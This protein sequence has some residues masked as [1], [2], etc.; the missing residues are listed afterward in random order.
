MAKHAH[1]V[2]TNFAV[3]VMGSPAGWVWISAD[4]SDAV[5][6]DAVGIGALVMAR[7]A[8][9]DVS[10]RRVA[11]E[12]AT[13]RQVPTVRMW[14]AWVRCGR[15]EVFPHVTAVAKAGAVAT[16]AHRLVRARFNAVTAEVV[17]TMD[18]CSVHA[19]RKPQ[20]QPDW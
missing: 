18:K 10:S 7:G 20:F 12:V 14:I 9:V 17:T 16:P 19:F 6:R 15:G 2:V 13:T 5:A 3:R 4:P 1:A 8:T 11:V